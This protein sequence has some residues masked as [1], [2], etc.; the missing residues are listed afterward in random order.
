VRLDHITPNQ[1]GV[2]RLR[3]KLSEA[4]DA[5]TARDKLQISKTGKS[6][7]ENSRCRP[8]QK[9]VESLRL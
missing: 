8:E 1:F 9:R 5:L 4:A 3:R 2:R 6:K 7:G